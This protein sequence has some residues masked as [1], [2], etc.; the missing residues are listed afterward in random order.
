M[1][2]CERNPLPSGMGS[3]NALRYTGLAYI[4][5]HGLEQKHC[6]P[7][8]IP[9]RVVHEVPAQAPDAGG[10]GAP[11]A[12]SRGGG[13]GNAL[14][15][16]GD[17]RQLGSLPHARRLRSAIRDSSVRQGGQGSLVAAA[18]PGV[19]S[20]TDPRADAMDEQLFRGDR[21]GCAAGRHQTVHREPEMQLTYKF[22]LRDTADSELRRQSRAGSYGD[23]L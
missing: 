3:A 23:L 5:Q 20:A 14:H 10:R 1:N 21:W 13:R 6:L 9:C 12:D 7:L 4:M 8:H 15:N 19:Q 16:P 22:R 18:A 2:K 17:G 11:K